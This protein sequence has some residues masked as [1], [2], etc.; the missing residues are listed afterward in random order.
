MCI[1][2]SSYQHGDEHQFQILSCALYTTFTVIKLDLVIQTLLLD[3]LYSC[4]GETNERRNC[5][6]LVFYI[7]VN[8]FENF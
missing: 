1:I 5:V 8:T 2:V 3:Y 6:H 7:E 4:P